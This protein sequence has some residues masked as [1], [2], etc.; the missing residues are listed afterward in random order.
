MLSDRLG[1]VVEASGRVLEP[2]CI[3]DTSS[4]K[5]SKARSSGCLTSTVAPQSTQVDV[6]GG[7]L[8]HLVMHSRVNL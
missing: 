7:W 6:S 8:N 4:G 2:S 5:L 3:A 1:I